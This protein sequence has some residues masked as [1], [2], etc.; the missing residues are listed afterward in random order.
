MV[1]KPLIRLVPGGGG[2]LGAVCWPV[3]IWSCSLNLLASTNNLNWHTIYIEDY[4]VRDVDMHGW[5]CRTCHQNDIKWYDQC[6]LHINFP[7]QNNSPM[8]HRRFPSIFPLVSPP[9]LW[10]LR[11]SNVAG[12]DK[13]WGKGQRYPLSTSRWN[14]HTVAARERNVPTMASWLFLKV[15]R[16]HRQNPRGFCWGSQKKIKGWLR[17]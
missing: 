11:G 3:M 6:R 8:N 13:W 16:E 1:N 7:N 2:T 12:S 4:N 14:S 17:S 15:Y 5:P 9:P 10:N